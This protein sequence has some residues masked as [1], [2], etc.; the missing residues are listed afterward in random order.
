VAD[1]KGRGAVGRLP[2]LAS[3]HFFQCRIFQYKRRKICVISSLN[4]FFSCDLKSQWCTSVCT[5][6][7]ANFQIIKILLQ[8]WPIF[9]H[10]FEEL[11]ASSPGPL[12]WLRPLTPLGDFRPLEP[13]RLPPLAYCFCLHCFRTPPFEILDPPLLAVTDV[14]LRLSA[15]VN[16]NDRSC[17]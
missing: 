12:P 11:S 5:K 13:L 3:K 16:D 9:A 8:I 14:V 6:L 10:I 4:F 1:S 17:C 7:C 15:V 2:L